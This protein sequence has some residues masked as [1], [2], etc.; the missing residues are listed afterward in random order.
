VTNTLGWANHTAYDLVTGHPLTTTTNYADGVFD[1]AVPDED[2][3]QS[4]EYDAHGN[5][6]LRRDAAGRATRMWYD[7]LNRVISV[8]VNYQPDLP[9]KL[10]LKGRISLENDQIHPNLP[11]RSQV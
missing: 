6:Y 7:E 11:D 10:F 3:A 1:S 4:T 8:T 5:P 9:Q 2:V